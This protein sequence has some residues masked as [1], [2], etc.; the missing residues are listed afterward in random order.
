MKS[1]WNLEYQKNEFVR[2]KSG[3]NK[4]RGAAR[5]ENIDLPEGMLELGSD[6]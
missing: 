4:L 3:L 2:S 6:D 1:V 5:D